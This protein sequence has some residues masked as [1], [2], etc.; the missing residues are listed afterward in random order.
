MSGMIF[1]VSYEKVEAMMYIIFILS[2]LV[3]VSLI[4]SMLIVNR[5]NPSEY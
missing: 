5:E 1:F 4:N 3:V 2:T